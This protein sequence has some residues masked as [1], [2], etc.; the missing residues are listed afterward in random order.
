MMLTERVICPPRAGCP[1]HTTANRYWLPEFVANQ[2]DPDALT[3]I[4]LHSTSFHKE[5]WEPTL[6]QIFKLARRPGSGVKL[7][8]AWAL[9]CPNHGEAVLYNEHV[10]RQDEHA[11]VCTSILSIRLTSKLTVIGISHM[12]KVRPRC[13]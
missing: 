9:D 10:L 3:L 1:F 8:E 13:P 2:G 4:L 12:P 6:D 5:T 11:E 7:R